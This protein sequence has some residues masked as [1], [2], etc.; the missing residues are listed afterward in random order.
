MLGWHPIWLPTLRGN[1]SLQVCPP[2]ITCVCNETHWFFSGSN[3]WCSWRNWE[4]KQW[5]PKL[6]QNPGEWMQLSH[7]FPQSAQAV[8]ALLSPQQQ[9]W[10]HQ[11]WFSL[12][13]EEQ[14]AMQNTADGSCSRGRACER[15]TGKAPL[16]SVRVL[17]V[18]FP[19]PSPRRGFLSSLE[20]IRPLQV[21]FFFFFF[22]ASV[23]D[24][25]HGLGWET[26][27]A[28]PRQPNHAAV[29]NLLETAVSTS[30]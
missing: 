10:H 27:T 13:A 29:R 19:P 3:A 5:F 12:L 28:T 21:F 9:Q 4:S 18:F 2:A 15:S 11:R 26:D 6:L 23:Q 24:D 30:F 17:R 22:K 25:A 8:H 16:R 1:T 7:V 20:E 14:W